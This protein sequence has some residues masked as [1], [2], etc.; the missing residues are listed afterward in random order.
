MTPL[1]LANSCLL[2]LLLLLF[3]FVFCEPCYN[4]LLLLFIIIIIIIIISEGILTLK[5]YL[6][7]IFKIQTSLLQFVGR[8]HVKFCDYF[9]FLVILEEFKK[10][11]KRFC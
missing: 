11:K 8:C 6:V 4:L 1:F 5:N 3:C 7:N 9:F 2:L 10:E